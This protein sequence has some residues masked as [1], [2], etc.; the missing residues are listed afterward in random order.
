[1]STQRAR[2]A[3]N[4]ANSSSSSSTATTA[5]TTPTASSRSRAA[6]GGG[7]GVNNTPRVHHAGGQ[8]L[9]FAP[10]L[11]LRAVNESNSGSRKRLAHGFAGSGGI[12]SSIGS[13]MSTIGERKMAAGALP[14]VPAAAAAA[15]AAAAPSLRMRPPGAA[16]AYE[17]G[18]LQQP[19]AAV[20]LTTN[21]KQIPS[22]PPLQQH[23]NVQRPR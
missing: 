19:A 9:G 18:T 1:M 15:A 20:R 17:L 2:L 6:G 5:T 21:P 16:G 8:N 10:A 22:P 13:S 7:T 23:S 3:G 14:A 11:A 12:S 4:N